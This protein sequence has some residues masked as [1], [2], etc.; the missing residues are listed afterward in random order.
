MKNRVGAA[1]QKPILSCLSLSL[2]RPPFQKQYSNHY[3][4]DKAKDGS[5]E[6]AGLP[7]P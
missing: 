6:N 4:R 5:R 1:A 2:I 3:K 7:P